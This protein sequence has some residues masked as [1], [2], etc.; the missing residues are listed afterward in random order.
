MGRQSCD[1][2]IF[3]SLIALLQE[4]FKQLE[5]ANEMRQQRKILK[6]FSKSEHVQP[7]TACESSK[8]F[9]Q[10]GSIL[11][12]RHPLQACISLQLTMQNKHT[13][14]QVNETPTVVNSCSTDSHE[15]K[16]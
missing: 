3:H 1:P 6:L 8:L 13:D 12:P 16:K 11:P 15:H 7:T 14:L 9:F 10:T 5:K 2:I 4:R